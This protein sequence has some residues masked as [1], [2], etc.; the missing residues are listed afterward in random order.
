MILR[1]PQA[2]AVKRWPRFLSPLQHPSSPKVNQSS[3]PPPDFGAALIVTEAVAL[4]V[5]SADEVAVIVT[6]AGVG[7]ADGAV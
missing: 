2:S 3:A 1:D 6:V 4:T 7:T 5:E